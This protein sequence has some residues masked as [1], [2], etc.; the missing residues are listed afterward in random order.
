MLS[1]ETSPDLE[2]KQGRDLH[3]QLVLSV[4]AAGACPIPSFLVQVNYTHTQ[5]FLMKTWSHGAK[6]QE[7]V[8]KREDILS[9]VAQV[10]LPDLHSA[11]FFLV[12]HSI[13]TN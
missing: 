12:V 8:Q 7:I 10:P 4:V 1:Q 2:A 11:L 3:I 13:F 5:K 9:S 6:N